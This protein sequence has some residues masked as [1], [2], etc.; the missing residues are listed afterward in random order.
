MAKRFV[1]LCVVAAAMAVLTAGCGDDGCPK[2]VI[3]VLV[4]PGAVNV[5]IC[6][7]ASIAAQVTG[8]KT[9]DVDWYIN[10]VLGGG[11]ALGTVTQTNPATYTAPE[12]FPPV[13]VQIVV[14]AVARE[15][16]S[17]VGS[18]LINLG[19]TKIYVNCTAGHDQGGTGCIT[20]PFKSI[21]R[22]LAAAGAGM[23]VLVA[24]GVY[25]A[26]NGEVFPITVANGVSLVGQ[27]WETTIIRG[28]SESTFDRT[29]VFLCGMHSALR[30]FTLEEGPTI[31]DAWQYGVFVLEEATGTVID[32]IRMSERT[33]ISNLTMIGTT[34]VTVE[35]CRFVIDDHEHKG[36]GIASVVSNTGTVIRNCVVSGFGEG[37]FFNDSSDALI[38]GCTMENNQIGVNMCCYNA[39]DSNP[40]PDLG[41]GGRGSAGGNI[42]RNNDICGLR[43]P[44][45]NAIYAR[46]NT[47]TH[48]PPVAGQDYCTGEGTGSI[49]WQ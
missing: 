48:N 45:S 40:N 38:E 41:G 33:R 25:D 46:F 17:K 31:Q 8:G 10:D 11:S 15:D 29:A 44:T 24:P 35:N 16:T 34:D 21:T 12:S 49:V 22:G 26:T 5:E 23:T 2:P 37:I 1:T 3:L 28:H 32:S 14:K 43:N 20:R 4:Y 7:T 13:D 27:N 36:G 18:C 42:I 9:G 19:L 47:W 30:R 39:P 6:Q